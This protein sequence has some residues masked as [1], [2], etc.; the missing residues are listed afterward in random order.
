M[1]ICALSQT[2]VWACIAQ[3]AVCTQ[4]HQGAGWDLCNT[5]LPCQLIRRNMRVWAQ[6]VPCR[7]DMPLRVDHLL[8]THYRTKGDTGTETHTLPQFNLA[9]VQYH[10]VLCSTTQYCNEVQDCSAVQH[11]REST[12]RKCSAHT[13]V[14]PGSD[15]SNLIC[16]L[17]HS[18]LGAQVA[19]ATEASAPIKQ[20][21]ARAQQHH[22]PPA[23]ASRHC[24]HSNPSAS[25][26]HCLLLPPPRQCCCHCC[27]SACNP[28]LQA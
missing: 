17:M 27:P 26:A 15:H 1:V 4:N 24:R 14:P 7:M 19:Q 18:I 21:F 5:L 9:Q 20:T 13:C 10:A 8:H 12:M 28:Q 25:S 2:S 11:K 23:A 6:H 22:H 3:P 16:L